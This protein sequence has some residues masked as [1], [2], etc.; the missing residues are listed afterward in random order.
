ME[1][2]SSQGVEVSYRPEISR[3]DLLKALAA[4]DGLV[5][6]TKFNIDREIIDAAPQLK[7]IARAGAGMDNV[8]VEYA[9]SKGI[10]CIHAGGA[11]AD[12][13]GEHTIAMLL[14]IYTKMRQ[15]DAQVRAGIW[16][17]EA[18]RG[19]EIKAKTIC[20]VGYGHTGR[21][22]AKKLKGF[23]MNILAYDKYITDFE[24]EGM[25]QANMNDIFE[26]AD[27]ITFHIPLTHETKGMVNMEYLN[28]FRK[29]IY[30]LNLSRGEI[31]V[32]PDLVG[33]MKAGKV[34]GCGL[35][36]LEN[37]KLDQLNTQQTTDYQYI[38]NHPNTI[39]SP[40]V[41]GWTHE[42]YRNISDILL[43]KITRYIFS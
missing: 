19:T 23:E 41:G 43:Q 33:A 24:E 18:N 22:V 11:N 30:I 7:L 12:A 9:E 42:S 31:L 17:R 1:G 35:D 13:V 26:Q 14:N 40:H 15:A 36:V 38:M 39:F 2:L 27:I 28:K 25:K 4:Y 34:I 21:A 16:N 3:G 37:E 10:H 5:V 29:K 32:T 6:R 20:I 8:D